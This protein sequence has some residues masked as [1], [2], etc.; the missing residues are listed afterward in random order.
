MA[1]MIL[2]K[3]HGHN[4]KWHMKDIGLGARSFQD[5]KTKTQSTCF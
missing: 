3:W 4:L 1:Q 5:G 2:A